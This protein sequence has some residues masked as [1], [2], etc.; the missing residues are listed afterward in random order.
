MEASAAI[1]IA[2]YWSEPALSRDSWSEDLGTSARATAPP[3][4]HAQRA[5]PFGGQK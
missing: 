5:I 3:K 2:L 1:R 4:M